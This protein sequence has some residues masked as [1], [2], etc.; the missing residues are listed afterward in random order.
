ML[1]FKSGDLVKITGS[2]T[3]D[4]KNM[5]GSVALI[6]GLETDMIPKDLRE[7]LNREVPYIIVVNEIETYVWEEEIELLEAF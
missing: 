1:K 5:A 4:R 3:I 6:V 2:V 7:T